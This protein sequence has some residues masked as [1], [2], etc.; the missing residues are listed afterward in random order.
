MKR[1][2]RWGMIGVNNS[3]AEDFQ[4]LCL[5]MDWGNLPMLVFGVYIWVF[6]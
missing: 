1:G 6:S 5:D 3:L 4:L 2:I